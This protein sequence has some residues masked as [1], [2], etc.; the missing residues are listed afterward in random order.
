MRIA[1][2]TW[3]DDVAFYDAARPF[4]YPVAR[5]VDVPAG[6]TRAARLL[7]EDLVVWRSPS[8]EVAVADNVCA[9][10]GTMLSAGTVTADGSVKCP[11]HGWEYGL[12]GACRRIPQ[13]AA[14]VPVPSKARVA[15]YPVVEYAGLVWTC[16]ADPGEQRRSVPECPSVEDP[17]WFFHA[18]APSDW[19][20]QAARMVENFLDVAHF[21]ILH[22]DTFGNPDVEIVEPYDVSTAADH[23]SI[24]AKVPYLARDPWADPLPGEVAATVQ[25]D[26]EYRCEL[27]FTGWI[28]GLTAGEDYVLFISASPV[29]TTRTRVFWTFGTPTALQATAEEVERREQ[30]VFEPDRFIVEGQRP[31]WLPLDLTSELQMRFDGLGVAFRRS[32]EHLGFPRIMVPRG[33]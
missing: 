10:R 30:A 12:D 26:Y 21:G 33:A 9:H 17:A 29:T 28:A 24:S 22:A 19:E 13:R 18:G 3:Q 1:P 16:L 27:P 20:C 25:V 4:W 5:S 8:G 32:L 15:S 2:A 11:Y 14:D 31:E 23:L 6:E 7:G